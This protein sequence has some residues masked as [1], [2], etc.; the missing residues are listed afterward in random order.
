LYVNQ[1]KNRNVPGVGNAHKLVL[2]LIDTLMTLEV[3]MAI[4]IYTVN[5]ID[6]K[7]IKQHTQGDCWVV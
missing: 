2:V 1:K 3:L 7:K 4:H 6:K 5:I